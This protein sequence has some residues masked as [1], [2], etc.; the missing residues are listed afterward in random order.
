MT[1]PEELLAKPVEFT[2]R[3]PRFNHVAMS[4]P[5]DL[6]DEEHRKLLVDFYTKVFGWQPYDM[7]T[8][9]R[10]RLV[11][12]A[13]HTEQ[14]VFLIADE[15]HMTTAKLDHFGMSVGSIDEF[16]HL[17]ARA[18]AYRALDDRV[19]IIDHEVEDHGVLELHNFYVR[20]L[21]PLMV[22]VQFYDHTPSGGAGE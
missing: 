18:E 16:E 2:S 19:E 4:L 21:L 15:P 1:A 3:R 13:Y 6:L 20:F 12:G 22:E 14:F 7:L 10:R 17:L 8:E 11:F 5:G 9:D